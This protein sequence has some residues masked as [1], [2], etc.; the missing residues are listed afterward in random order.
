M[1]MI[2]EEKPQSMD[3]C[4][5]VQSFSLQM[6]GKFGSSKFQTYGTIFIYRQSKPTHPQKY[7]ETHLDT[8]T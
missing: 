3:C 7:V 6:E 5:I 1:H 2:K 4:V 8:E